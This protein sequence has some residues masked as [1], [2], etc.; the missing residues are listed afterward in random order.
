LVD[1]PSTSFA[2]FSTYALITVIGVTIP[3][4]GM[5]GPVITRA[6]NSKVDGARLFAQNCKGCHGANGKGEKTR[7]TVPTI[8]D[9]TDIAWHLSH[10]ERALTRVIENG[11]P[12]VMPAYK[13]K[14]AHQEVLALVFYL[15]SFT[16]KGNQQVAGG[17]A[18]PKTSQPPRAPADVAGSTRRI[19]GLFGRYC[20]NCHGRDGRGQEMRT[21]LPSI[22]DFTNRPW[23]EGLNKERMVV[24]ILQGKGKHM[25]TFEDKIDTDQARKLAVYVRGFA[26]ISTVSPTDNDLGKRF[27]ELQMHLRELQKQRELN[28]PPAKR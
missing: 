17:N 5:A 13:E 19:E 27:E 20:V 7:A 8:P 21:A 22:P 18:E 25:P 1:F 26:G 15:R 28:E 12:P 24:S 3:N 23:Q 11:N 14:L 4:R 10:D 6:A 16:S 2:A 9:F